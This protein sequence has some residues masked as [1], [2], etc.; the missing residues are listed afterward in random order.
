MLAFSEGPDR[1]RLC[2]AVQQAAD[3]VPGVLASHGLRHGAERASEPE[4]SG[5]D[6][7]EF[8]RRGGDQPDA[9][10]GRQMALGEF[11]RALPDAVGHRI[12]VDFLAER[13]DVGNPVPGDERQRRFP[14]RLDVAGFL[15]AA[16]PEGHLA[17][18]HL[19]QVTGAEQLAGREAAGEVVDRGA[20]H[21]RVVDVEERPGCRVGHRRRLLHV[22][23]LSRCLAGDGR[24]VPAPLWQQF[25]I[26][27]AYRGEPGR[28]GSARDSCSD[29]APA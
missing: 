2:L 16:Q 15:G 7:G 18:G 17:P 27:R 3:Q 25:H 8:D 13:D 24:L 4:P 29:Q 21:Q 6:V 12:V 14:G 22:G 11:P 1:L 9:L 19:G 5:H 20:A 23:C 10:A 26:H 28:P